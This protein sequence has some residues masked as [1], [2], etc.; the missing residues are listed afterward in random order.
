MTFDHLPHELFI[1]IFRY[2]DRPTLF[3][4]SIVCKSWNDAVIPVLWEEADVGT[5]A[6]DNNPGTLCHHLSHVCPQNAKHIR[7][8]TLRFGARFDKHGDSLMGNKFLAMRLDQEFN[9]GFLEPRLTSMRRLLEMTDGLA[10]LKLVICSSIIKKP[11]ATESVWET[12]HAILL[13]ILHV[14]AHAHGNNI[15]V[16]VDMD[17]FLPE[18]GG[19]FGLQNERHEET[20]T[21]YRKVLNAAREIMNLEVIVDHTGA[22][23]AIQ[24]MVQSGLIPKICNVV[25]EVGG[26][27][28]LGVLSPDIIRTLFE[29]SKDSLEMS[30]FQSCRLCV[31]LPHTLSPTLRILRIFLNAPDVQ[32][33]QEFLKVALTTLPQLKEL[34]IHDTVKRSAKPAIFNGDDICAHQLECLSI[35]TMDEI[36]SSLW[37]AVGRFCPKVEFLRVAN[38]EKVTEQDIEALSKLN[39]KVLCFGDDWSNGIAPETFRKACAVFQVKQTRLELH[40]DLCKQVFPDLESLVS[41]AKQCRC[42]RF[43]YVRGRRANVLDFHPNIE[44]EALYELGY[45]R[46]PIWFER[47]GNQYAVGIPLEYIRLA[48]RHGRVN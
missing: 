40:W 43:I 34:G 35:N 41:L 31:H 18:F 47:T 7:R 3:A 15:P 14:C 2:V 23:R 38:N 32:T 9:L 10:G 16:N 48:S 24:S 5:A 22:L 1:A 4:S 39:L 20:V 21:F 26:L 25:L 8:L 13:T 12:S 42:L 28:P 37:V 30:L 29:L 11:D 46:R 6:F 19:Q 33:P 44:R 17:I 27:P 36:H 45:H